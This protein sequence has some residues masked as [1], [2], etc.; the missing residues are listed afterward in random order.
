MTVKHPDPFF[1]DLLKKTN[2][3]EDAPA[4]HNPEDW[5]PWGE[6]AYL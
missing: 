4:A 2:Q 3:K 1:F 5:F 6:E